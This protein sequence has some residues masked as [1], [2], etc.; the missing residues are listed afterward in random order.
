MRRKKTKVKKIKRSQKKKKGGEEKR[1]EIGVEKVE[2]RTPCRDRN[3][4]CA[5]RRETQ[6]STGPRSTRNSRQKKK[7]SG[8]RNCRPSR[9]SGALT[10]PCDQ[11]GETGRGHKKTQKSDITRKKKKNDLDGGAKPVEGTKG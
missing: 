7:G 1:D 8:A 9:R 2:I 10:A 11:G 4:D 3:R 6:A 5:R